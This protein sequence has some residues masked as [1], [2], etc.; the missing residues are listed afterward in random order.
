MENR[1]D[2]F[3]AIEDRYAGYTV[4]DNAGSKIGKVDDLFLDENDQ[5]EYIGVKMGFLGTSSTLIPMELATTDESSS[6]ITVSTD[7]ETAKNGPAFNADRELTPD[8]ENEVRSY[9]GLSAAQSTGSYGEYEGSGST[10][11][12][13]T[14]GSTDAGTVGPGMSSGDTESGEFREHDPADEGVTQSQGDD[15]ADE[16]ELRVQRSE[17]ELRAGTREREAGSVK[18]RKRV[19]TDRERIEVPTRHEEVSFA[20]V[21]VSGEATDAQIGEDEVEVPVTEEEV[22]ADKRAVAKEEVRLR[23]D[24]VEG[25]E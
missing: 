14:T 2:G 7:K 16:D 6:S 9:Y 12:A 4:Y 15:L 18:V 3:T 21:P 25:T 23:K 19:R 8:Y 10:T 24:V 17:E 13:G 5:P 1:S 20:R 22:V 11:G